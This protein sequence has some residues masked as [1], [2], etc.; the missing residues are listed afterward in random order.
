[1]TTAIVR[2]ATPAD[3]AHVAALHAKA[4]DAL[5]AEGFAGTN[6]EIES[7]VMETIAFVAARED[8][9]RADAAAG[10]SAQAQ[11]GIVKAMAQAI[12]PPRPD[13]DEWKDGQ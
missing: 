7:V 9:R 3:V 8:E 10:V 2:T 1:M 11:A 13:G 12:K 6:D 5:R 4:R